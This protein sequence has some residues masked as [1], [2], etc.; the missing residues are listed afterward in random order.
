M[1]NI[2]KFKFF[3]NLGFTFGVWV[4]KHMRGILIFLG[5]LRKGGKL[6]DVEFM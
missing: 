3:S 2:K 1:R 6:W 4:R 5:N